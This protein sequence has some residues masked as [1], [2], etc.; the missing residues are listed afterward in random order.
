M[1]KEPGPCF[2]YTLRYFWSETERECRPFTY[3]GCGGN[4]NNFVSPNDCYDD[5]GDDRS[6]RRLYISKN[7]LEPPQIEGSCSTSTTPRWFYDMIQGDCLQFYYSGCDERGNNFYT[8]E[9]CM[10][11]CNQGLTD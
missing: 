5:C 6:P 8:Y 4:E 9:D 10:T 7:C 11:F 1:S 3:G 2:S